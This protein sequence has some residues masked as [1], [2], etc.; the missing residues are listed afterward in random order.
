MKVLFIGGTGNIS[1]IVSQMAV[2]RG[3]DLTLLNRGKQEINM[4]GV[5]WI[6]ADIHNP[7]EVETALGM[8]TFDVVVNWIAFTPQHV[9]ADLDRFLGKV[10][11]YIF[12]SSASCYQKP[13]T[14]II[15]REFNTAA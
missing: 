3:I 6:T 5:R 10:G 2:E 1:T 12:I 15:I 8:E 14:D 7:K 4:P 13:P 11:Q 9:Q